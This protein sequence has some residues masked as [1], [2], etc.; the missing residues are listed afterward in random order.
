V[1]ARVIERDVVHVS[2]RQG[3]VDA[4]QNAN[5]NDWAQASVA[6]IVN[7]KHVTSVVRRTGDREGRQSGLGGRPNQDTARGKVHLAVVD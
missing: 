2:E 3:E 1:C 4:G 6:G 5:V 7:G